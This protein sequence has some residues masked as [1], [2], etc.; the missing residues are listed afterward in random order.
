[1]RVASRIAATILA[2]IVWIYA[3]FSVSPSPLAQ[4]AITPAVLNAAVKCVVELGH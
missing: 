4:T 3:G 1:M 2:G